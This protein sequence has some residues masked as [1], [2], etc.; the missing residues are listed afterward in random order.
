[1]SSQGNPASVKPPAYAAEADEGK[2]G[3]GSCRALR[4]DA[5]TA[6]VAFASATRTIPSGFEARSCPSPASGSILVLLRRSPRHRA[7]EHVRHDSA[8]RRLA[9]VTVGMRSA[10]A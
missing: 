9:S 8:G 7:E 4:G 2:S 5:R 1:M 10:A 3:A 6:L